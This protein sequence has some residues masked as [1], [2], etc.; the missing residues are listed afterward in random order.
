MMSRLCLSYIYIIILYI[1]YIHTSAC[2]GLSW[3][4][5]LSCLIPTVSGSSFQLRAARP[6]GTKGPQGHVWLKGL[7]DF[8]SLS[9]ALS[10]HRTQLHTFSVILQ[11]KKTWC[12]RQPF[13]L[14]SKPSKMLQLG[15]CLRWPILGWSESQ[16]YSAHLANSFYNNQL[17][18]LRETTQKLTKIR[19][20]ASSNWIKSH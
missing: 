3:V 7:Q 5:T 17:K 18:K 16:H 19:N 11:L 14:S 12:S 13:R 2:T 15:C 9:R 20:P 10:T 1:L 8:Y 4:V 6:D